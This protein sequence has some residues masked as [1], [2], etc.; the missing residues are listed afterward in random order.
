MIEFASFQARA[1][2]VD[3]LG[4]EQIADTPT[5]I[6]ELWKNSYDAYARA[7]SLEIY[8]GR[9]P[10][11]A[12]LDDGHGMSKAEFIDRWLVIGTESKATGSAVPI[13]DRNGLPGRPKLGQKGIGRLSCANLGPLLLLLSKR[14]GLPFV[15]ALVDWRLFENPFLNFADVAIPHAEVDSL[16]DVPAQLDL[17]AEVLRSNVT[18]RGGDD[19][20]LK[21]LSQAWKAVDDL[22]EAER[23]NGTTGYVEPPSHAILRSL[24]ALPF[25]PRHFASWPVADGSSEHGTAMIVGDIN[26]DLA[27]QLQ[28]ATTEA[29]AKATQLRFFETLSSFVDPFVD[30]ANPTS[31]VKSPDFTYQVR[32]WVD[33]KPHQ[34]VGSEK[35]FNRR[36]LDGMEHMIDGVVDREGVFRGRV[37]AFGSWLEDTVTIE[38]PLDVK[39]VRRADTDVGIFHFYIASMEFEKINTTLP[40]AEYETFAELAQRYAGFMIFRD[41]L[42]VLPYGRTDNDFFEIESRRSKHA[43]REFWNHRQMFGRVAITRDGN[44][45]LKDKAGREGLLDNRAAKSLKAIVSNVLKL[46]ARRYFGSDSEIRKVQLPGI[47]ADNR[48]KKAAEERIKLRQRQGKQ[49]RSKLREQSGAVPALRREVEDFVVRMAVMSDHDVVEAQQAL[50]SYRDR[51]ADL[52]LPAAPKELGSLENKY[53]E[54]RDG[55]QAVQATLAEVGETLEREVERLNPKDPRELLVQQVARHTSQVRNRVQASKKAI[56]AL[57]R[58]EYDRLTKLYAERTKAFAVDAEPVLTQFDRGDLRYADATRRLEELKEV[59]AEA[60]AQLFAPYVAALEY[61]SESIDLEHLAAFGSDENTELRSELDRLN[62]LAQLGIA[63]E[64][65]GHELQDY[66]DIIGSGLRDLPAEVRESR[67]AQDIAFGYEGLTDQLRFLTPLRLAGLKVQRWIQGHEIHDYV[68]K[69]FKLQLAR[70]GIGLEATPAFLAFRVFD[71]P[72]RLLPVFIN[73]TNNSIYW[74]ATGPEEG[75]RI[76]FDVVAGEVVVSD[77][78]PG[79][80]REDQ[81][82]L[83]SLFFTRKSVGGRGVGLYLCKANLAA[84]GHRIRYVAQADGMPLPGANFAI[85]FKGASFDGA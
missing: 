17:M 20:R 40:P 14:R 85:S 84:G 19:A 43:G 42:R 12:L 55:L 62:A 32:S 37:K 66:D 1:R 52:R 56:E 34:V 60:N 76:V 11:A 21:R 15:A 71:Q 58:A 10:V 82:S 30:P 49:F 27:V 57:Q 9:Q 64:I 41:G 31:I 26:Y 67:A 61:L 51:L 22:Y 68:A 44:P 18:G 77:T 13:E 78:G 25:E 33:D 23:E 45:N 59:H 80:Q 16:A 63:V 35:Q 3:H 8:D 4:R 47:K 72:S 81:D 6:S 28:P 2:T 53:L 69:F 70:N 29:T 73:L 24:K 79:V 46:T 83:F 75:R 48:S 65:A 54:Y 74:A 38:P 5:A 50:E 36:M 39:L 7:V